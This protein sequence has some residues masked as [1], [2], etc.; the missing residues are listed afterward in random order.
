MRVIVAAAL[1][2]I[3]CYTVSSAESTP[4]AVFAAYKSALQK[5]DREAYLVLLTVESRAIVNPSP[6]LMQREYA[7][8]KNLNPYIQIA[9]F[10]KAIVSFVPSNSKIPPYVLKKE[11]GQWKVDLKTMSK[12]YVFNSKNEWYKK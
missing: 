9:A 12:E 11:S 7:D 1:A 10:D 5:G 6:A 2:L 4:E 8:I 3:L